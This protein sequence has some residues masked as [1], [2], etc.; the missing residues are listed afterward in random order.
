MQVENIVLSIINPSLSLNRR[1]ELKTEL[2]NKLKNLQKVSKKSIRKLND[3]ERSDFEYITKYIN[4]SQLQK[5]GLTYEEVHQLILCYFPMNNEAKAGTLEAFFTGCL[6]RSL[7]PIDKMKTC[8][9]LCYPGM[10]L[11][12]NTGAWNTCDS[13]IILAEYDSEHDKYEFD[14]LYSRSDTSNG[15]IFLTGASNFKGFTKAEKNQLSA[16]GLNNATLVL[17]HNGQQ[18]ELND[19]PLLIS[20]IRLRSNNYDQTGSVIL[21]LILLLIVFYILW[22]YY[23]FT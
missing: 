15:V 9:S 20:G 19:E 14:I 7:G 3:N 4:E 2:E 5:E 23:V 21:I 22:R 10:P 12:P 1:E 18:I 16:L 6:I 8:D 11:S 13:N 17:D